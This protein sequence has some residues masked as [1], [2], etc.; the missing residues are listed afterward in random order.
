MD[1][2]NS[3]Q[4]GVPAANRNAPEAAKTADK[5]IILT[6]HFIAF[7]PNAKAKGSRQISSRTLSGRG[8][9]QTDSLGRKPSP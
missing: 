4:E 6:L 8:T 5:P 7:S 9:G 1:F 3:P 2:P